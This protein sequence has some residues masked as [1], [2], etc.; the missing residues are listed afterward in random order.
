M[1]EGKNAAILG[2][3]IILEESFSTTMIKLSN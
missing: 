3:G 1:Q 2:K